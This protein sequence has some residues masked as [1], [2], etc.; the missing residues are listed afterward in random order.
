MEV[1]HTA[2]YRVLVWNPV[3]SDATTKAQ[4]TIHGADE[5]VSA[6]VDQTNSVN[7]GWI[8]IGNVYLEQG[9]HP[10]IEL[11]ASAAGDGKPSYVSSA[12]LLLDRK[13]S[14]DVQIDAVITT[15]EAQQEIPV[16]FSLEQNYPNPF[17]PST[18]ITFSL[19]NSQAVTL[20]VFNTI[21]QRVATL[22]GGEI[23]S[24]GTHTITFD[25]SNLAS[26]LYLY[27]IQV[28]SREQSRNMILMK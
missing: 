20:E 22:A 3:D 25:A 13:K 17:N 10:V 5:K 21:G 4:F 9:T 1:P 14:P 24:A 8:T 28:G 7:R 19:P 27:R 12:M 15:S 23:F 6:V 26:G 2:W 18:N 11:D 16:N